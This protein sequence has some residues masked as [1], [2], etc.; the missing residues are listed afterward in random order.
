MKLTPQQ[1]LIVDY[2]QGGEWKCM[3]TPTLFIKDDRKRI[4]EL[5]QKG[6]T[7]EG[8]PCTLCKNHSS[9]V[10]MRRLV[11]DP[12]IKRTQIAHTPKGDIVIE[13]YV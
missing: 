6:Y 11:S 13:S 10:F 9:K 4:S 2:L 12:R 5:N 3:A 8:K 1:K 7:I